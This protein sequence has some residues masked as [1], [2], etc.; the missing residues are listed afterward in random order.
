MMKNAWVLILGANSDMAIATAKQL[1]QQG[2]HLY[3]AGREPAKL[4]TQCAD[5][6]IRF[7]VQTKALAFDA[8]KFDTHADFYHALDIKPVGVVLAF[9][10][11]SEQLEASNDFALAKRMIDTNYTGAVSILE[12]VANDFIKT[13]C[14]GFIVGIS[15]VA[16]DRGRQSNYIYGSTKAALSTYLQGLGHRMFQHGVAVVCV[17]PGFVYT[18]MTSHLTLPPALTATPDIVANHI[19][20]SIE[21][22]NTTYIYVKPIW[23]LIMLIIIHIPGFIF[24]KTKL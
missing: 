14:K 18:K 16:G 7:G 20:K 13:N 22:R 11:M 4:E 24:N 21:K 15:S 3:L 1:A 19:V 17:K 9:G 5:L 23:R 8:C 6:Q 2:Y 12:V 10:Y